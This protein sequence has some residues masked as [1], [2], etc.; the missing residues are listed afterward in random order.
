MR[1]V[2]VPS[3]QLCRED[4]MVAVSVFHCVTARPVHEVK[5]AVGGELNPVATIAVNNNNNM[6]PTNR[7]GQIIHL[8][9]CK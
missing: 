1:T 5:E 2:T 4:L 7:G 3:S 9:I 6:W 8:G